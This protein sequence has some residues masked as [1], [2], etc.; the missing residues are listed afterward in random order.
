MDPRPLRWPPGSRAPRP[1]HP[2]PQ[3]THPHTESD[4]GVSWLSLLPFQ[5]V[6]PRA[7][8]GRGMSGADIGPHQ[9]D[10]PSH[11]PRPTPAL[12]PSGVGA[13]SS[14]PPK[15]VDTSGPW[16]GRWGV[17]GPRD[18]AQAGHP[19]AQGGGPV[20]SLG[21]GLREAPVL[22]GRPGKP[23]SPLCPGR[24]YGPCGEG[25]MLEGGRDRPRCPHQPRGA[26]TARGGPNTGPSFKG[27]AGTRAQPPSSQAWRARPIGAQHP[28]VLTRGPRGPGS[29]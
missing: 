7:T 4:A 26:G 16:A 17:L 22:T 18:T 13:R 14:S 1:P 9:G 5:S 21:P 29:P 24:P 2:S 10:L 23:I 28:C 6:N 11:P 3:D 8:L 15:G 27:A 25:S 20:H 12:R 19:G